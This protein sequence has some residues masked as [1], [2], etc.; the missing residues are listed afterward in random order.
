MSRRPTS[1][2]EEENKQN[3]GAQQQTRHY[4]MADEYHAGEDEGDCGEQAGGKVIAAVDSQ[5]GGYEYSHEE[6]GVE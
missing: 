3:T 1:F 4:G 2:C 5:E 6:D